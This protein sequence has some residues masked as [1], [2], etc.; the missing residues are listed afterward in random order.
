MAKRGH[1]V[2]IVFLDRASEAGRD[3]SFESSFLNQL[4][5][6]NIEFGFIGQKARKNPLLGVLSL[7]NLVKNLSQMLFTH[8][9]I[10]AL[11]LPC[12]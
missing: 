1:E 11:F 10:M 9:Y 12:S 5:E 3:L 8:I 4:Q 6:H 2:F 7:R